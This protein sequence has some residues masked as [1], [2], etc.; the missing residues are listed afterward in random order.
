MDPNRPDSK[1]QRTLKNESALA[2]N[3]EA[4]LEYVD[5]A[6]LKPHP[7]NPRM[8]SKKQIRK[9]AESI[10]AF[11]FRMPVVIDAFSRLIAGH[12]RVEACKLLGLERVPALRVTDLSEDQLRGLMI[13]DNRLTELGTW[14]DELLGENLKIL[15]ELLDFDLETIGFEY[16][17]IEQRIL[18]FEGEGAPDDEADE[19]PDSKD[20]PIVSRVG[21]LW[22]LGPPDR[23]HRI[24][25]GDSREASAYEHLLGEH[26]AAMVFTDPPY[27]LPARAI[28]QVCAG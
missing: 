15:S 21:D 8:H 9:I 14:D 25:C 2:A 24:L 6:S 7:K 13:A 23:A 20:L 19:V 26:C 3:P 11:G 1:T 10:R 5:V 17:E 12:A 22:Q 16:G 28:G 27:N 18:A 4:S